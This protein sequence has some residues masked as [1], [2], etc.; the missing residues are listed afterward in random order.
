M[1]KNVFFTVCILCCFIS[2]SFAEI[3]QKIYNIPDNI[4]NSTVQ[5]YKNMEKDKYFQDKK[6]SK[7]ENM[8]HE[9]IT[10]V[11]Y[12]GQI[13][14]KKNKLLVE[15]ESNTGI[16]EQFG[17]SLF[18]KDVKVDYMLPISESYRLGPGDTLSFYL[19]GDPV[20][21]LGLNGFYSIELDRSGKVFIPNLGAIYLWGMKIDEAKDIF[22]KLLSKKFKK[23][24]IELTLGKVKNF[25]VYVTG[26]VENQGV[27]FAN[28][29]NSII[30][31]LI[32]AGGVK[33]TGT[34]RD[35]VV[36]RYENGTLTE[37]RIDLYSM[38]IS[39]DP[40]NL[41]LKEGDFIH[42][43]SI[44]KTFA[45]FGSVKR[46][47]IYE[48]KNGES[49]IDLL[50]YAGGTLPSV[51]KKN[52]RLFSIEQDM[53]TIFVLNLDQ[54]YKLKIKDGDILYFDDLNIFVENNIVVSGTV[55]YPGI[56]SF[57]DL[58]MLSDVIKKVEILPDTN[59]YHG[60]IKR[61]GIN[62]EKDAV[63][64]FS[65]ISVIEGKVD[66]EIMPLDKIVFYKKDVFKPIEISGEVEEG[67][68]IPYYSG[69]S[70]MDTLR[71]VKFK[72][73]P[74]DLK[75]EIYTDN[76]GIKSVYLYD[77][78]NKVDKDSN[79][80]LAPGT[81]ILVK[82]VQSTEKDKK[83]TI[84]G[85]VNAPGV[86]KYSSGMTLY[87]II[88]Q[89][90]GY[91][92]DAYPKSLIFIRESAKKLQY[93]Q[94]QLMLISMEESIAKSS[95]AFKSVGGSDE[96]KALLQVTL[97]KQKKLLEFI[98]RKAEIGLGR[99]SL[100]VPLELDELSKSLS[101]IELQDGDYIYV[102]SKPNYVL[103]LGSVYNQ[104]SLP[105]YKNKVLKDYVE[106][107]GGASKDADLKD[108]YVIK[109]NGKVV[110]NRNFKGSFFGGS[111]FDMTLEQGD[112]VVIPQEMKIPTLWRPLIKD[113]TQ[114]IFQALS[115]AVLAKRL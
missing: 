96:E 62:G 90:G 2:L 85:E 56:Y 60:N 25:P 35:I 32:F 28:G 72:S 44:G 105:H 74:K 5:S 77:L 14:S 8:Y 13:S 87:D 15:G 19:W 20:E 36:K 16:L 110:S 47:G 93:E 11:L 114:I 86:Y 24:E 81:K 4:S 83:I 18:R 73:S 65:P 107:V 39:G 113:V 64:N 30:D 94:L 57:K 104:I 34:L 111:F 101:N 106:D 103:V 9:R 38:L 80:E 37:R 43:G 63:I 50:K 79:F 53:Q 66:I 52:I 3:S 67:L 75:L 112:T 97:D 115:T 95:D 22:R 98:K 21:I 42:V 92:D 7:I 70:I 10:E 49:T 88:K 76:G 69:I 84:L 46:P 40:L 82:K 91:T 41:T 55:K 61:K 78:F 6:Y 45:M 100:D 68:V 102:P 1:K 12:T 99:I 26:E 54:L 23:F 58:K 29:T 17:Y 108:I 89:A 48:L 27:V 31:A 109:S 51:N 33:K 71:S 59:L